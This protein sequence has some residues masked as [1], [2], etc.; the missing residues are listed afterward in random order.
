MRDRVGDALLIGKGCVDGEWNTAI[1]PTKLAARDDNSSRD[2]PGR[3]GPQ[4]LGI[5]RNLFFGTEHDVALEDR[6]PVHHRVLDRPVVKRGAADQT[7]P[8]LIGGME[9]S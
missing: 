7:R 3:F 8:D 9:L 6:L 2:L 5:P 1:R 4:F